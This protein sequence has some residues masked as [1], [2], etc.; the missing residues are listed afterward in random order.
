M[1]RVMFVTSYRGLWAAH[2]RRELKGPLGASQKP[3]R[4]PFEGR[5]IIASEVASM[6]IRIYLSGGEDWPALLLPQQTM[7]PSTRRPQVWSPALF[8]AMNR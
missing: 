5:E 2:I 4:T 1:R 3:D 8:M 7:T 6:R